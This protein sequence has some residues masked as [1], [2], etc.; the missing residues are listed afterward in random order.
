MKTAHEAGERMTI[1][2]NEAI[3]G[4]RVTILCNQGSVALGYVVDGNAYKRAG[5]GTY[6]LASECVGG[7]AQVFQDGGHRYYDLRARAM[8]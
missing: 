1:S 8:A 2:A 6:H 3:T 7:V 4:E 5:D